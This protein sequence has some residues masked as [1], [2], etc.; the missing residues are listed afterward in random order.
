MRE[1]AFLGVATVWLMGYP[2]LVGS[3][4]PGRISKAG[5]QESANPVEAPAGGLTYRLI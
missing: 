5:S 4:F 3:T 2:G 1:K